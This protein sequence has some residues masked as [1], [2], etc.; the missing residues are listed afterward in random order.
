[1]NKTFHNH[2]ETNVL[3]NCLRTETI[4]SDINHVAATLEISVPEHATAEELEQWISWWHDS[5][6]PALSLADEQKTYLKSGGWWP[7]VTA[8]QIENQAPDI[9]KRAIRPELSEQK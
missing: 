7:P 3:S 9:V 8:A 5:Y 4:R 6:P 1:M 2:L